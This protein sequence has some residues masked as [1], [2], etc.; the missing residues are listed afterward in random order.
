MSPWYTAAAMSKVLLTLSLLLAIP[1]ASEKTKKLTPEETRIMIL[2]LEDRVEEQEER[3]RI[4]KSEID[5]LQATVNA[6]ESRLSS[7]GSSEY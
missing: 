7:L 2:N 5:R 3:L 1:A 4:H 6:L